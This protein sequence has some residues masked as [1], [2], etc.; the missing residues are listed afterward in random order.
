MAAEARAEGSRIFPLSF[1]V[2]YWNYIG[3]KDP[4]SDASYSARQ[5]TY[6]RALRERTY[7]PQMIVNGQTS[8]VGSSKIKAQ[9]AVER[10]L[11]KPASAAVEITATPSPENHSVLVQYDVTGAPQGAVLNLAVVE[12]GLSQM[13]KRGENRNRTLSHENVVRAF[14]TVYAGKGSLVLYFPASVKL[15]NASVFAY[16]QNQA[17]MEVLGASGQ[18]LGLPGS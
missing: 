1:H 4:Y 11:E 8:F 16:A 18:D 17:T 14:E 12:R 13:V 15:A 3:W 6:T 9:L 5:R 10:A 7:T 2:D